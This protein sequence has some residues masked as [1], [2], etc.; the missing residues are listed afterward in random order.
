MKV[1]CSKADLILL[2]KEKEN[3]P[4]EAR[5]GAVAAYVSPVES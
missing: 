4:S 2:A 3:H 1:R 5:D